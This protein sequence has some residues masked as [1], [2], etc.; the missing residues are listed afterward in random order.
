MFY[1]HNLITYCV[2][3]GKLVHSKANDEMVCIMGSISGKEGCLVHQV[4]WRMQFSCISLVCAV[5]RNYETL[6]L[7]QKD[8][9]YLHGS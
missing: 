4:L 8:G 9:L 6:K 7:R 3:L 1:V 2:L 5:N